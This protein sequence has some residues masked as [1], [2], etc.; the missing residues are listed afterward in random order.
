VP[1]YQPCVSANRT[2]GPPLDSPSCAPPRP[3]SDQLTVGTFDANGQSAK[4]TAGVI[5]TTMLGDPNSSTDEADVH[6]QAT[7][8][9][10]R[11]ASG[12]ADFTGQ[13]EARMSVRI[14][15]KDNT[16]NPGG[17]GGGTV[18]DITY[19]FPVPCSGTPNGTVGSTC[20]VDTTAEA[21]APGVAKEK[22]RTIWALGQVR[23]HDGAG[24]A[25]MRQGL[26]VP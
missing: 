2:H 19:L 17:P 15:D 6:L 24:N 12:L 20:A 5:L 26:F 23:L 1:A 4:S 22:K 13:L 16:P 11:L 18:Q 14:T 9:D 25:F 21:L 3:S 7:V 8:T 10:V